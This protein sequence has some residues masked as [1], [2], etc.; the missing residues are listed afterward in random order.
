MLL[1][2]I[3]LKKKKKPRRY[4]S[5]HIHLEETLLTKGLFLYLLIA[6]RVLYIYLFINSCMCCVTYSLF[7]YQEQPVVHPYPD[8]A[9]MQVTTGYFIVIGYNDGSLQG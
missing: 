7:C 3:G 2:C 4:V 9:A 5:L 1:V 6:V 8:W